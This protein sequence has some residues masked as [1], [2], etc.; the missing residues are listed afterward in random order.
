MKPVK[1][2]F[3]NVIQ[4]YCNAAMYVAGRIIAAS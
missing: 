4:L 3:I 2:D 1:N